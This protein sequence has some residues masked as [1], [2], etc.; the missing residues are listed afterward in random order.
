MVKL[1]IGL[2][3]EHAE[4]VLQL[5]ETEVVI[6]F[7]HLTDMIA[8]MH[9]LTAAMVWWGEPIML[10]ILLPKVRQVRQFTSKRGSH[11]SECMCR[12]G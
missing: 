11:P 9:C 4:G 8:M 5:S 3:Q 7:Q 2:G 12:V 10:C 1:C 6:A